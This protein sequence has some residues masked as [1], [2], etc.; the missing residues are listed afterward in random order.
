[1]KTVDSMRTRRTS[2]SAPKLPV[3]ILSGFLGS[4][5]TVCW[6]A[7]CFS[8]ESREIEILG[9]AALLRAKVRPFFL[10]FPRETSTSLL[11]LDERHF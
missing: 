3:T 11:G 7:L 1:M 10:S 4:G 9:T 5:K 2:H 8:L 6:P